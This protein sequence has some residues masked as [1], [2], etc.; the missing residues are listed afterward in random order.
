MTTKA[1]IFP[2]V[3]AISTTLSDGSEMVAS[4]ITKARIFP[5]QSMV[6]KWPVVKATS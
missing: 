2:K 6:P 4:V 3:E 5:G 1:C